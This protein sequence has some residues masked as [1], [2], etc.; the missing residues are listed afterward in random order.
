MRNLGI[1][2]L[3]IALIAPPCVQAQQGTAASALPPI[4]SRVRIVSPQLGPG[5]HVGVLARLPEEPV[6]YR[7]R[8]SGDRVLTLNEVRIIQVSTLYNKGI[9]NYDPAKKLY[10]GEGWLDVSLEALRSADCRVKSI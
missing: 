6:C 8:T 7:V 2:V 3:V 10:P 5:W 9:K 4:N 1:G